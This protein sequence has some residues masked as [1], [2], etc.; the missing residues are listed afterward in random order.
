MHGLIYY[1]N[2]KAKCRHLKNLPIKGLCGRCLSEIIDWRY[3]QSYFYFRP[4]FV[5]CCPSP[6]LSG[7]TLPP[8]LFPV[9]ILF[10]RIQYLKGGGV[11]VLGLGQ[12]NICPF[13]L[14]VNFFRRR[15]FA[16]PSMSL[17]FLRIY[18]T[19]TVL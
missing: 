3:D 7:S 5:N 13:L 15:H 11:G 1:I 9:C 17:V 12:M 10:T 16:L 19:Y 18:V 14:Q 2:N 4:S 6:L 8:F